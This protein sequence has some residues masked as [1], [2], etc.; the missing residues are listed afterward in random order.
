MFETYRDDM[1]KHFKKNMQSH[2][3]L[4]VAVDGDELWSRYLESFAPEHNPVYRKRTEHDCSTCRG[5][6]KHLGGM[7]AA[8]GNQIVSIWD[9]EPTYREDSEVYGPVNEA[10]S[11]LVHSRPI[12]NLLLYHQYTAGNSHNYEAGPGQEVITYRHFYLNLPPSVVETDKLTLQS[13]LAKH[14]ESAEML[15]RALT[16]ISLDALRE[17]IDL[18]AQNSLY[19]GEEFKATLDSFFNLKGL[20]LSYVATDTGVGEREA[21][22]ASELLIWRTA[23]LAPGLCRIRNSVIGTLLVDLSD[24]VDLERAVAAYES[25]V[26]PANYKRPK[27][28]ITKAMVDKAGKAMGELGY[29]TALARRHARVED[30]T[31]NNV[32]FVDRETRLVMDPFQALAAELPVKAPGTFG[33]IEDVPIGKFVSDVLPTVTGMEVLFENDHMGNLVSLIAPHDPTSKSMFRWNN[34]FSWAYTGDVADSI[35][36]RVKKAGGKVDGFFRASLSWSNFDDLDLSITEPDGTLIYFG[37][38]HSRQTGGKLD[39]D[40]NAMSGESREPVE[41]IVY[42]EKSC[43]I[44]GDYLISVHQY[45]HRENVDHGFE[46]EVELDGQVMTFGYD[47]LVK[48]DERIRVATMAWDARNRKGEITPHLSASKLQREAWGLKTGVFH[49]V[50]MMTLSPNHWDNQGVGNR[51]WFFILDG[52]ATD[53]PARGFFNEF[54]KPELNEHRKVFEVMASRMAAQPVPEQLSGLGFSSTR[55][56]SLTVRLTGAVSR[57]VRVLF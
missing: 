12:Q 3:L 8:V 21:R 15:S 40:M 50:R 29:T 2:P 5:F 55:R 46:V 57:V 16:E 18:V 36:E 31:V 30:L 53:Q 49:K 7:V 56:A 26:A 19:R 9:F 52:C 28:L 32:L 1:V 41:N 25:K 54:L 33:K 20:Y 23:Q 27:S 35:R 42:A 4:R 22:R 37:S 6:I 47:K 45:R 13:K 11:R 44:G 51:H 17:A 14:R 38:K 48:Q 43:L 24:G 39:V 10:M 34:N